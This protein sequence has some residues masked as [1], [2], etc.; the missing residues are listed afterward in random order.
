MKTWKQAQKEESIKRNT[1]VPESPSKLPSGHWDLTQRQP[2][3]SLKL[4]LDRLKKRLFSLRLQLDQFGYY[5]D[6]TG[7]VSDAENQLYQA[8]LG[9]TWRNEF[10][11]RGAGKSTDSPYIKK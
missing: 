11:K 4:K 3:R 9:N 8:M 6:I 5:N 10:H 7:H 1:F 2:P